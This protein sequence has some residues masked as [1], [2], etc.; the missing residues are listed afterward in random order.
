MGWKE[1]WKK[2]VEEATEKAVLLWINV[3]SILLLQGSCHEKYNTNDEE[4]V[5]GRGGRRRRRQ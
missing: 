2:E 5:G 4:E 3:N 1:K